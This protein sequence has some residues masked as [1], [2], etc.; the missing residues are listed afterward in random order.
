MRHEALGAYGRHLGR[1][2]Q[3]ADDLLDLTGT[4]EQMGKA[5]TKDAGAGKQTYPAAI[6]VAASRE[7]AQEAAA[8]ATAALGIFGPAADDLRGLARFVVERR[9]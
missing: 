6:G 7:A 9:K 5:V 1:A 2:F 8:E 3:I 4:A